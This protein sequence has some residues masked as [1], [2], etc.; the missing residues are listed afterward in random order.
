MKTTDERLTELELKIDALTTQITKGF[1]FAEKKFDSLE[2]KI[3]KIQD[4]SSQTLG[5]IE[6]ELKDGFAE[7]VAEL[8]KINSVTSYEAIHNNSPKIGEA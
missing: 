3:D 8:K 1:D 7:V 4:G 5:T 2:A 6:K